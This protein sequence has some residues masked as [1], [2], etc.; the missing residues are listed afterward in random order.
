MR[1]AKRYED[2]SQ[3]GFLRVMQQPDGDMVVAI[4]P[5]TADMSRMSVEFCCPGTGGG[6]SKHTVDAL[7]ALMVAIDLDNTEQPRNR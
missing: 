3:N 4:W 5:G 7:R 2:M 6:R 1:E